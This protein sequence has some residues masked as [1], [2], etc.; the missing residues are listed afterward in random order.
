MLPR[1][2]SP[3]VPTAWTRHPTPSDAICGD[4]LVLAVRGDQSPCYAAWRSIAIAVASPP[5]MQIAATPLVRS[6]FSMALIRVAMIRAPDAPTGW[7]RA[8]APPWMLT[9]VRRKAEFAHRRHRHDRERLI[10]LVEFDLVLGPAGPLKQLPHRTDGCRGEPAR[11]LAVRGVRP[12]RRQ[13]RQAAALGFGPP[14]HHQCGSPVRDRA[15][16]G[17][18]DRTVLAEGGL[19]VGDLR[20]VGG[21]G[22]FIAVPPSPRRAVS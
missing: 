6:C 3:T 21:E 7:P 17:R 15:R 9:F 16:V 18:R 8:Q 22:L 12:D 10:D 2:H 4:R 11:L 13:R 19:Q 20:D 14:H 1:L 5:P